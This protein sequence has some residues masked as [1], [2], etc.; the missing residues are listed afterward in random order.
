MNEISNNDMI[1]LINK[2]EEKAKKRNITKLTGK[3]D[4][5]IEEKFKIRQCKLFVE[6]LNDNKMRPGEL[7]KL[8]EIENSRISEI[9]HYKI[10][11][12]TVD[13]LFSY[14]YL[15]GEHSS[16]VKMHLQILEAWI[17]VP[18]MPVKKAQVLTRS[19]NKINKAIKKNSDIAPVMTCA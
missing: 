14:L 7:C 12:F 13:K 17:D 15:L 8:L 2:S 19:I 1:D 5:T 6:Y 3:K 16:K 10:T 4:L 11:K 18:M 9:I